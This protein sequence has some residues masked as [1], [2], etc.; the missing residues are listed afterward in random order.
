MTKI[1]SVIVAVAIALAYRYFAAFYQA[2]A[3][4]VKRLGEI[5]TAYGGAAGFLTAVRLDAMF[6][7]IRPLFRVTHR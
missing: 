3:R 1:P 5:L 4:E 7:S 6:C 2:S